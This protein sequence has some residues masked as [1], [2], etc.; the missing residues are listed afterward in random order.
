VGAFVDPRTEPAPPP[1]QRW[2]PTTSDPESLAQLHRLCREGRLYDVERWIEAGRPLQTKAGVSPKSR[3][4][5]SALEIALE[6][7]SHSLVHLLLCNGYDP[8]LEPHCPLD[9]ALRARRWDLID[10]LLDWGADPQEVDLEDLFGTYN[11]KL[12][13][14]F[15]ALG[16]DMTSGH[17]LA[18][19]LAYH[20]SNKPLFGFAKRHWRTD[21]KIRAALNSA[22]AYHAGERNEKGVAL[23]LWAGADPHAP[24]R[25]LR[26]GH[27]YE[28]DDDEAEGNAFGGFSAVYEACLH[29]DVGILDRLGPDP[30][31]D[32]FDELYGAARNGSVIA[33][34]AAY[35]FPEDVGEVISSHLS[36]LS[37]L[38]LRFGGEWQALHALERLF[39][40]GARW[41]SD[42]REQIAHIRQQL[43][44]TSDRIFIDLMKLFAKD[45]Y[46]TAE[47]LK[48]LGRTPA[49]RARMKE[50]GFFP[51]PPEEPPSR[52]EHPRPTRSREVLA[53]F[54][55]EVPKPR[56]SSV[57]APKPH[58]S[59]VMVRKPAKRTSSLPREIRIGA[60][61]SHGQEIRLDRA[62]L[63][64][65]VWSEPVSKLAEKWGISGPGLAK[66]CRRLQI[67]VPPRGYWAKSR[68]GRRV[69]RPRL[70][71]VPL[72]DAGEI[73]IRASD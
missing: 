35:A 48:E 41:E 70:P 55:V 46:C 17:A 62:S 25:T 19:A 2:A 47:V 29:G 52:Y 72:G 51:R 21:A 1:R 40:V 44:K 15:R 67:P 33:A 30:A 13:E 16:V 71:K 59:G 57:K 42:S 66:A 31:R 53:K 23:C 54:G 69:R 39:E 6:K 61:G 28:E 63:F 50:V 9:L 38:P 11:S 64:D 73:V 36:H 18:E 8:N 58:K 14:R 24:A 43:L 5:T 45:E 7:E 37:W 49:I 65:L 3:R 60:G 20:T 26:F 32:D 10:L 68:A 56:K 4:P 22:L 27:S 34:L 12:F